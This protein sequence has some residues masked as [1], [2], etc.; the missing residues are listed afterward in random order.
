M[1]VAAVLGLCTSVHAFQTPE[2][3]EIVVNGQLECANLAV[4]DPMQVGPLGPNTA[5]PWGQI[6]GYVAPEDL[7]QVGSDLDK[8][9]F[10]MNAVIDSIDLGSRTVVY[11]G[12]TYLLAPGYGFDTQEQY[13]ELFDWTMT[14]I[15]NEDWSACTVSGTM[16]AEYGARQP[17]GWPVAVDWSNGNPGTF[18]GTFNVV[19]EPATLG[20][21]IFGAVA[22]LLRRRRR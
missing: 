2:P 15:Y 16:N 21:V 19:P 4:G 11:S 5:L 7:P 22:A 20:L 10:S 3:F 17:A 1:A 13:L 8:Y 14:A 18:T 9:G 12:T 6:V